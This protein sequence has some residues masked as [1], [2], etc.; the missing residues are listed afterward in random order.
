MLSSAQQKELQSAV[1][2][3]LADRFDEAAAI[4][5]RLRARAPEDFQVNHLLGALRHQQGRAREAL[6]L[7]EK[8][9]RSLPRSAPT[10]MCLGLVLSALGRHRE[11]EK[12]LGA[13]LT[14][15]PNNPEGWSNLGAIYA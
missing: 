12:A 9:R 2:H 11:A 8:A 14:L 10:L 5:E 7:L 13:S 4:Y 6:P 1:A 15:A 3:H